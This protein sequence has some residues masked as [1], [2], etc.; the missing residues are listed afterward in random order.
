MSSQLDLEDHVFRAAM[1]QRRR[2]VP[3]EQMRQFEGYVAAIFTA[4]G[5]DLHTSAME[6]T[7]RRFLHA[8]LDSTEGY[9]GDTKLLTACESK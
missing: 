6:D 5:L 2:C 9:E 1:A 8:L 4:F 3:E 7:P